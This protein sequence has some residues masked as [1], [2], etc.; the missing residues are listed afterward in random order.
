MTRVTRR[1]F[2][3]TTA[4]AL[5]ATAAGATRVRWRQRP[6]CAWGLSAWEIEAIRS[7]T[8]LSPTRTP[9]V[10]AVC[11]IHEPYVSFAARKA[12]GQPARHQRLSQADRVER[13]L[14]RW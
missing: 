13:T 7:S 12:G 2:G 10:V 4:A 14:M 9:Q 3:T 6:A 11:D 8:R 1:E 5:L